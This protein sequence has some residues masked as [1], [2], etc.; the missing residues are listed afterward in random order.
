M[1]QWSAALSRQHGAIM[2]LSIRNNRYGARKQRHVTKDLGGRKIAWRHIAA[3][4][5]CWYLSIIE[6]AYARYRRAL[7]GV[8]SVGIHHS[9][10]IPELDPPNCPDPAVNRWSR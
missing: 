3:M 4:T 10:R 8:R 7:T 9:E 5:P 6:G 2:A 1:N